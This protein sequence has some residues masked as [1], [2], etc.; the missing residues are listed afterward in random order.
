M[1]TK[2]HME[3]LVLLAQRGDADAFS[4]LIVAYESSLYRLARSYLKRQED[5]ADAV[6]ETV[7]KSFRAIRSLKEPAYFKTWLFRILVHECCQLLRERKRNPIAKPAEWDAAEA[8]DPFHAI[9]LKEAVTYLEHDLRK[10]VQ[11]YYYKDMTIRQIAKAAGVPEG[12]VKSR[13][14]RAREQLAEILESPEERNVD[15]DPTVNPELGYSNLAPLPR[16]ARKRIRLSEL[17]C[18]PAEADFI[19]TAS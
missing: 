8:R 14:H 5:C 12:T 6:Q 3:Q 2:Q 17:L 4:R 1:L 7:F 15:H 19:I 13:L 10:I 16:V 9:E 11:L 18:L